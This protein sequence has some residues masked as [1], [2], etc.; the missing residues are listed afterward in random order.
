MV[1]K[2]EPEIS[3]DGTASDLGLQ[4]TVALANA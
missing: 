2:S 1:L 3:R 4:L